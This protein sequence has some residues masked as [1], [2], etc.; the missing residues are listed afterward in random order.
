MGRKTGVF[1]GENA[2][3]IRD[4]LLE[5]VRVLEIE[6]IDGEID[7]GFGPG[8]SHLRER[9]PVASTAFIRLIRASLARHKLGVT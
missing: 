2:T 4:E 7:L 8:R 6:R 9:G 1:A 3:L 5:Q